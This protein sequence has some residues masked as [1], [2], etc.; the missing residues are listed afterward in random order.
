MGLKKSIK[1]S[2]L[3][4]ALISSM[5]Y[6][7]GLKEEKSGGF[8]GLQ[9]GTSLLQLKNNLTMDTGRTST[10][11]YNYTTAAYGVLGGYEYWFSNSLG[12]RGYALFSG[13]NFYVMQFG[14]GADVIYNITNVA[15]GNLG[16]I[17][18]LQVG[19]AYWLNSRFWGYYNDKNS[20]EFDMA[21]NIGVR[22]TQNEH[23]IELLGKIP[24]IEA[25][26]GTYTAGYTDGYKNEY[27]AK[28]TFSFVARY[29]YR[30]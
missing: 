6:A 26:T 15:D 9:A 29:I 22:W 23:V 4:L 18:G 19:G 8:V 2:I 11:R 13:A 16:V 3:S 21:L 30:F 20:L 1:T 25:H 24:F 7:D 10:Y 17:A 27:Y 12:V 14:V 28:E 5:A